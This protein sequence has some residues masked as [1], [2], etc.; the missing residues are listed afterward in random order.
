MSVHDQAVFPEFAAYGTASGPMS[1]TEIYETESGFEVRTPRISNDGRH[2]MSMRCATMTN[3]ESRT[4]QTFV[5]AR[6]GSAHAFMV[7]DP[8]DYSS[9][10]DGVSD[11][12][13]ESQRQILGSGNGSTKFFQLRK[14]Y[15]SGSVSTFHQR[16]RFITRT[17]PGTVR[18]WIDTT[19]LTE[20]SQF[21]VDH[22][23]GFVWLQSAPAVGTELKASFEFYKPA[24][25]A[26]SSDEWIGTTGV[27]YNVNSATL[28]LLEIVDKLEG[29]E[30][31][32]AGYFALTVN[33]D[34]TLRFEDGQFQEF[35][36]LN[37]AGDRD[38]TMWNG[39]AGG[40]WATIF[41]NGLGGVLIRSIDIY[42]ADGATLIGTVAP[43]ESVTMWHD[44]TSWFFGG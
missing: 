1:G 42:Q 37:S 4:L 25:I 23:S 18:L 12:S 2:R 7:K 9:H 14:G 11:G 6:N 33:A 41:N 20:G 8:R 31:R 19:E 21:L 29:R 43:G 24:I 3:A 39:E 36:V 30:D 26:P 16:V 28:E 44:G 34:R 5:M 32:P 15:A 40:P 10:Q 13:I 38:F 22:D 17:V 35:F 27:A